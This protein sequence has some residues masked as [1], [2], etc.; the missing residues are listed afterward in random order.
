MSMPERIRVPFTEV[1]QQ[2]ESP[3]VSPVTLSF[4]ATEVPLGEGPSAPS[5]IVT[6]RFAGLVASIYHC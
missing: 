4:S 5:P 1:T 2:L 6:N 3:T